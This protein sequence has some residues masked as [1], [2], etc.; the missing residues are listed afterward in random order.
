MKTNIRSK[1]KFQRGAGKEE[2]ADSKTN[3][4]FFHKTTSNTSAIASSSTPQINLK[5]MR[6]GDIFFSIVDI[7]IKGKKERYIQC[8]DLRQSNQKIISAQAIIDE[9]LNDEY[10]N[11]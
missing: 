2:V 3:K 4:L 5:G 11:N 10:K 7:T 1:V 9:V 8:K 6:K